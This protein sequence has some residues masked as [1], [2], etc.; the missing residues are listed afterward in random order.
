LAI[1][2]QSQ[3]EVVPIHWFVKNIKMNR[4]TDEQTDG[5]IGRETSEKTDSWTEQTDKQ[6]NKHVN[7]KAMISREKVGCLGNTSINK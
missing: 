5:R 1:A 7:R 6:M 4:Q 3:C 2:Y